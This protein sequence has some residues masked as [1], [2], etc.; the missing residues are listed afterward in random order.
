[1]I[2]TGASRGFGLGIAASFAERGRPVVMAA[3]D[4]DDLRHGAANLEAVGAPVL[5]VPADV[6]SEDDVERLVARAIARFGQIDVLVN[7][8]G[9]APVLEELDRLSWD[10]WRHHVD[11]DLRGVFNTG[12]LVGP[13]MRSQGSGTIVNVASGAVINASA[14]HVSYSPAQ[15]AILVLSRCMSGWLADAGVTVHCLCPTLT[16]AGGVGRAAATTFA[17]EQR[18]RMEEWLERRFGD[19]LLTAEEVGAAVV[20]LAEEPAGAVWWVS[21]AGLEE[22]EGVLSPPAQ[23]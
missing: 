5:A 20:E 7:N 13:M 19:D 3:R 14:L 15:A 17:R 18:L 21:S 8:A 10:R 1:V 16:P 11:V 9:A 23:V 2:V 6:T 12:R 4:E 22:W